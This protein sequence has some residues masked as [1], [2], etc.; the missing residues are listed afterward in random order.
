MFVNCRPWDPS[1]ARPC[2][3][4]VCMPVCGLGPGASRMLLGPNASS[5]SPRYQQLPESS[6]FCSESQL[7][8]S[9]W[10][11]RQL[12]MQSLG[13][14]AT[15]LSSD[16][17]LAHSLGLTLESGVG[18]VSQSGVWSGGRVSV[19]SLEWRLIPVAYFPG[20]RCQTT[21]SEVYPGGGTSG[22]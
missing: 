8:G 19:W 6:P 18:V 7:P 2:L 10:V 16:P 4:A 22:R 1:V 21:H 13:C 3:C 17:S 20:F 14:S 9:F 11:N 15:C 12:P 5:K